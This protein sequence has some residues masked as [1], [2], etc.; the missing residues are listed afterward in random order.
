MNQL[1]EQTHAWVNKWME[2]WIRVLIFFYLIWSKEEWF[3]LLQL[4]QNSVHRK[5][6]AVVTADAL[7]RF[8]LPRASQAWHYWHFGL[9]NSLLE[10][11]FPVHGRMFRSIPGLYPIEARQQ[12]HHYLSEPRQSRWLLLK[13][14]PIRSELGW[15][16]AQPG[17]GTVFLFHARNFQDSCNSL[18]LVQDLAS[19]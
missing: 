19:F 13:F 8:P 14:C 5:E 12:H 1:A 17:L 10:R 16:N 11:G 18:C 4:T 7:L 6:G 2:G 9:D 3:L 15:W